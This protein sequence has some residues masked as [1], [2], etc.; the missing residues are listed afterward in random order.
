MFLASTGERRPA[1]PFNQ[2]G[3]R[4]VAREAAATVTG[5]QAEEGLYLS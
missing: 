4:D 1:V 3:P 2:A 5:R